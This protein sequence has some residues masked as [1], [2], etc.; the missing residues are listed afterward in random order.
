MKERGISSI[1][2]DFFGVVARKQTYLNLTYLLFSFPLGTAYFI[3]LVTGL[4]MGLSLSITLIGIPILI[5]MLVAWWELASFERQ[6]A[7]WLL[8]I[9]IPP[10]E[11]RKISNQK[12]TEKLKG[13][14]LNPVTW[15]GL[16]FLLIKFPLGI[17]TLVVAFILLMFTLVLISMPFIYNT[18]YVNFGE[19]EVETIGVALM[20]MFGGLLLGFVSLH[21][22]NALAKLSG[23]LAYN[24]L[25]S[26][27]SAGTNESDYTYIEDFE[28]IDEDDME[29]ELEYD[30]ENDMDDKLSGTAVEA[31]DEASTASLK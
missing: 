25:G 23:A 22:M 3:F 12:M 27:G 4:S 19:A 7:I 30:A 9:D 20:L 18:S 14:I 5:L 15:K 28:D 29:D 6:L 2:R 17:F 10:M 24:L 16:V 11:P 31:N 13:Y 8:G 1:I 26:T 21:I